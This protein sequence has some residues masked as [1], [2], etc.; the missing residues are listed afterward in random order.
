[1]GDIS[2]YVPVEKY[3]M[4]ESIHNLILQQ[5]VDTIM[6]RDGVKL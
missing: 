5:V 1:M 3:G 2:V 6:E 4:A